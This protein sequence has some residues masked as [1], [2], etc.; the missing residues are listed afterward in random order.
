[1][2]AERGPAKGDASY[3][4][5]LKST[6]LIGGSSVVNIALSIIRNKVMAVLLGPEGVGLMGIYNSIMDVAI[7]LASVGIPSSGVRQ[8]AESVGSGDADRIARTAT[9]LRRISLV[10]GLAGALLLAALAYPVSSFTFG[11]GSHATALVLLSAAVLLRLVSGGQT[12]L[13]QGTRRIADLVRIQIIGGILST[14]VGILLIYCFGMQGIAPSL[15]AM[16]VVGTFA[17]WWYSRK[18]RLPSPP[19]SFRQVGG[20]A[21]ALLK[22]GLAFMASG[23]LAVGAA[24]AVRMIVLRDGGT[25]AAG[26]Y[27]AAWGLGGLYVGIILQ[28]MGA[29]F[30]PRLTAVAGDNPECNRLVNEQ[31]QVS[32]LLAAP[33]VLATLTLAP[34]VLNLFYSPE[35][36]SAVDML[37]WICLGMML[38]IISWPMGFIVLAKN[39]QKIFFLTE[40]AETIVHV[41]LAWLLVAW[42]GP[43]GAGIA[44]FGAYVWH[45]VFIY[46]VVRR[47][48][49]FRWSAENL[50]L[51][52]IFLPASGLVFAAFA[53]LPFWEATTVGGLLVALSGFYSLY[54]LLKLVPANS[55]QPVLSWLPRSLRPAS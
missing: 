27:Q 1:M 10:L 9:V 3:T 15:V 24:Y 30:Y 11:D 25:E 38:R 8:I 35:F 32:I 48:S 13:I 16:A 53:L 18:V 2:A 41:A 51:S 40:V 47:L 50:K 28:S 6:A 4:E 20:E 45:T 39:A 42:L 36:Q 52:L 21:A 29:D 19:M 43:I 31:T 33:G 7:N 17:T 44:F 46:F 5:I 34:L 14:A 49:G 26:L 12:A 37:R 54:M 23:F 55:L 22:L